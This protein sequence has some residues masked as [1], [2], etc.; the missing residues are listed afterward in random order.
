MGS[1]EKGPGIFKDVLPVTCFSQPG[2]SPAVLS[3]SP[4]HQ[5]AAALKPTAKAKR[6]HLWRLVLTETTAEPLTER[7]Q[8]KCQCGRR[9][10][11]KSWHLHAYPT[12]SLV[13]LQ[14][15]PPTAL[16]IVHRTCPPSQ[17]GSSSFHSKP[18][19]PWAISS[20]QLSSQVMASWASLFL[21]C[22]PKSPWYCNI[23]FTK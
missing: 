12:V 15:S 10:C 16:G 7:W 18:F 17:V 5:E 11:R 19:N 2:P 1:R 9:S 3:L 8:K 23:L 6:V 20:V 4:P 14:S 22:F 21:P 13:V